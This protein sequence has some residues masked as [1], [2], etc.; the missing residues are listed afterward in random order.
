MLPQLANIYV[1]HLKNG[2]LVLSCLKLAEAEIRNT[3]LL[4]IKVQDAALHKLELIHCKDVQFAW[5]SAAS[6][7]QKLTS[8]C[9]YYCKEIGRHIIEDIGQMPQLQQLF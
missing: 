2:E 5:A 8:L 7:L 9:V 3:H 6:Q 1:S 4:R